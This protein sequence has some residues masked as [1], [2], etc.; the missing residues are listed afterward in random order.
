V[1]NPN[2]TR[3]LTMHRTLVTVVTILALAAANV[4][5]ADPP[6]APV[7]PPGQNQARPP[8]PPP[9]A[10][11]PAPSFTT[12]PPPSAQPI[13]LHRQTAPVAGPTTPMPMPAGQWTYTQQYGWLWMPYDQSYTQVMDDAALAYEYVYYPAFGWSWVVAPWVLGFGVA[14]YWGAL[15]PGRFTWYAHPWFRVGTAH[16]HPSWGHGAGP[17]GRF[18]SGGGHFGGGHGRR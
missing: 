8:G 10:A 17:R 13:E 16:L 14:P 15:G 2:Q 3:G 6:P 4:A 9:E 5:H 12:P 18:G 7:A 1:A 11:P